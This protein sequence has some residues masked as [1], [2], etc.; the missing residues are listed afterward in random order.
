M[1]ESILEQTKGVNTM[2]Y[3]RDW[4]KKLP[5]E[6]I[7]KHIASTGWDVRQIYRALSMQE[8]ELKIKKAETWSEMKNYHW[9]EP[10]YKELLPTYEE[11]ERKIENI[12]SV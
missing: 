10:E 5:I 6:E 11:I 9:D 4:Y 8:I 7:N 1:Q 12:G 2:A 3:D